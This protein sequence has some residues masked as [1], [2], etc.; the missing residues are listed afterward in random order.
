MG[1]KQSK[2]VGNSDYGTF[3]AEASDTGATSALLF[4]VCGLQRPWH[5]PIAY[6]LTKFLN[7]DILEQL[8][9]EAINLLTEEVADVSIVIFDGASKNISMAEK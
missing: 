9:Y 3:Q 1:Q 5:V 6:F 2:F 8:I 4:M 7:G